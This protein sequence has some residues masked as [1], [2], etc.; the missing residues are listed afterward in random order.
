MRAY[1]FHL[2]VFIIQGVA[3]IVYKGLELFVNT[4]E[5]LLVWI[6]PERATYYSARNEQEYALT[7]LQ[8]LSQI[9]EAKNRALTQKAWCDETQYVLNHAGSQLVDSFGWSVKAVNRHMEQIIRS[10][11]EGY[12]FRPSHDPEDTDDA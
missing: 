2:V 8:V 5:Q 9:E 10:G 7:E 4:G 6:S 12:E 3:T 1:L 11:P